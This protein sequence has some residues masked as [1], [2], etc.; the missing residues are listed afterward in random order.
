MSGP[1]NKIVALAFAVLTI[2][3]FLVLYTPALK[4]ELTRAAPILSADSLRV[5]R[6][7]TRTDA[8]SGATRRLPTEISRSVVQG[9]RGAA[10]LS[11]S[12]WNALLED[13]RSHD[14]ARRRRWLAS[15]I[16][17]LRADL[18]DGILQ[19]PGDGAQKVLYA[20]ESLKDE[21]DPLVQA[22]L[23]ELLGLYSAE[24]GAKEALGSCVRF[25]IT[26][27]SRPVQFHL[28]ADGYLSALGRTGDDP[29]GLFQLIGAHDVDPEVR[30]DLWL[31][32]SL[33]EFPFVAV[34]EL[35]LS[36]LANP[37]ASARFGASEAL[38][39]FALEG[40]IGQE[41]FV[42]C[43]AP[44]ILVESNRRNQVLFL[45]TLGA[46]G[47]AHAEAVME[48]LLD[49]EK[50]TPE[51]MS[52]AA[53]A[54]ALHGE[55]SRTLTRFEAMLQDGGDRR[56]A[57]IT[58]LGALPDVAACDALQRV[59]AD[60]MASLDDRRLA[61]RAMT[62][63]RGVN[64]SVFLEAAS[65]ADLD[66]RRVASDELLRLDRDELD[67]EQR[68][69]VAD[70]MDRCARSD[71]DPQVRMNGLLALVQ[72][73]PESASAVLGDRIAADDSPEVRGMAAGTLY[74]MGWAR[75]DQQILEQAEA[76]MSAES[77]PVRAEIR[78][79]LEFAKNRTPEELK[80]LLD[81]DVRLWEFVGTDDVGV[82]EKDAPG[83]RLRMLRSLTRT[84][85][86]EA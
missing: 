36:G 13:L 84:L 50:T 30:R 28:A 21:A 86:G 32:L 9:E 48:S 2:I 62:S 35:V 55:P 82:G 5:D 16:A 45:E 61:L 33:Y 17:Y 70:A 69:A 34:S 56:R 83:D 63:K 49:G 38:R 1:K 46:V 77:L 44:V 12:A 18:V 78:R 40:S 42:A 7:S 31:G 22:V 73:D 60:P 67:E 29:R 37:D 26:D 85:F 23:V 76:S 58:A 53:S 3:A 74:L 80:A 54:L 68:Q 10:G 19:A 39:L 15:R 8:A 66:L 6:S 4:I 11:R 75:G 43:F 81:Q 79:Q 20:I 59:F 51:L 71:P 52:L 27:Q 57:A 41:E 47:G 14:D 64:P 25:L 72:Q 24:P 65:A